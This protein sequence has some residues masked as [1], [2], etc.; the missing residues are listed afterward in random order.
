MAAAW[1]AS[2]PSARTSVAELRVCRLGGLTEGVG[3]GDAGVP[4]CRSWPVPN[5]VF[6]RKRHRRINEDHRGVHLLLV[7]VRLVR[8]NR[9]QIPVCMD[10]VW[11]VC[12]LQGVVPPMHALPLGPQVFRCDEGPVLSL[13]TCV[14]L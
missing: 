13:K 10:P 11:R 7:G 12:L 9:A 6:P 4:L 8:C 2:A 3:V 14:Y 5:R 1:T